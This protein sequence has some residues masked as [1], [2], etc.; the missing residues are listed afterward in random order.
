VLTF[1]ITGKTTVDYGLGCEGADQFYA[2]AASRIYTQDD[3]VIAPALPGSVS[4]CSG[5]SVAAYSRSFGFSAAKVPQCESPLISQITHSWKYDLI[6]TD[7]SGAFPVVAAISEALRVSV[8][9]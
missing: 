3:L 2:N 8:S 4:L 5:A 1:T 6:Y 9:E 7:T